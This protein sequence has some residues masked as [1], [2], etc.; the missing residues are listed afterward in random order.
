MN[1]NIKFTKFYLS[2]INIRVTNISSPDILG[3]KEYVDEN[4]L[5]AFSIETKSPE[6]IIFTL[7]NKFYSD[8]LNRNCTVSL[9]SW[10]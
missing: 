8:L 9:H 1:E 7:D 4:G 2:E 5:Y 6:N 3:Y 10:L